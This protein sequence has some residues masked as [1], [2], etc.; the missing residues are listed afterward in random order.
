MEDML[1]LIESIKERTD[2]RY[3]ALLMVA[4][5]A[6]QLQRGS[7][8]LLEEARKRK[9]IVQAM[10]ELNAGLITLETEE[11]RLD[12]PEAPVMPEPA[13]EIMDVGAPL[14]E[15]NITDLEED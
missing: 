6:K 7:K 1:E 9:T 3:R 14:L 12:V 13:A 4:R 10:M 5:R 11:E 15:E 8:T 2:S